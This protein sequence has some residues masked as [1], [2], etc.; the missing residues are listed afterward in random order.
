VE[1]R[2]RLFE[3]HGRRWKRNIKMG[4]VERGLQVVDC[5]YLALNRDR[6]LVH[7]RSEMKFHEMCQLLD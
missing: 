4:L 3:R 7:M 5:V 6:L 1:T 2:I